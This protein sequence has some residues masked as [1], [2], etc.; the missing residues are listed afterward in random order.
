MK[1]P[2]LPI[3]DPVDCAARSAWL[4]GRVTT[5]TATHATV[6]LTV[7]PMLLADLIRK[8]LTSTGDIDV[9]VADEVSELPW[10][11]DW[12]VAVVSAAAVSGDSAEEGYLVWTPRELPTRLASPD[13]AALVATVRTLALRSGPRA[14]RQD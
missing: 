3:I 12:D 8:A 13:L 1:R 4:D 5:M 10:R 11:G 7:R 6:F 14:R 2:T 9:V